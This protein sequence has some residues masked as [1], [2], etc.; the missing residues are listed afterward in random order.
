MAGS[1]IRPA[2]RLARGGR[3]VRRRR[4]AAPMVHAQGT[5]GTL[6]LGFWDHWV[7]AGNDAMRE[8]CNEWGDRNRVEVQLDFITSVG[9]KNLLTIAAEAQARQRP[10]HPGL[11]DLGSTTSTAA[12]AGGRRD[13]PADRRNTARST[14][15]PSTSAS[16]TAAGAAVPGDRRH[17]VQAALRPHRP[18]EA[19]CRA[20]TCRRCGRP[21]PSSARAPTTGT[22]R[23]SCTAAEKCHAAGFPFGL[24]VGTFTDAVDWVGALFR[25]YGAEHGGRATATSPSATTTKMRQAMDY[26]DAAVPAPAGRDVRGLGRRHQQPRADLRPL[27]ADL[28]PALG[29]GGGEARRAAGGGEVLALPE[30]GRA[31]GPFVPHLPYFWGI[32]SF[33]REQAGG[34]G[35]ARA[36]CRER[37]QAEKLIDASQRLRHPALRQ[38][39]RLRDLGDGRAAAGDGL[40]L[41]GQPHHKATPSI[42]FAP[43]PAEI[44]VQMYN[45][46][47][48]T[49]MIARMVQNKRDRSTSALAWAE[50]EIEGFKRG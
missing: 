18:D 39:V 38:H 2:R 3:R 22:G 34:E 32:W 48:Q 4:L 35:A 41:P 46:G 25:S 36:S 9:N 50:R 1:G 47:I 10:R 13:G 14:R 6:A 33:S 27:G 5:G 30:P 8:H 16:A 21:R 44:A 19:A 20:S 37:E 11:P 24:P 45:Q 26:A 23:P 17:P 29:L 40:Q 28:Q 43:A 49:K 12:R 42:A 31:G 7:P 15:R